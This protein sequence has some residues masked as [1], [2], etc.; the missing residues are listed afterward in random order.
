MEPVLPYVS[1]TWSAFAEGGFLKLLPLEEL[2]T[3]AAE[4]IILLVPIQRPGS[5]EGRCTSRPAKQT[6]V[7]ISPDGRI[8]RDDVAPRQPAVHCSSASS[9]LS[10]T[11]RDASSH[12][13]D[14]PG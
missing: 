14:T 4:L 8:F 3:A 2:P 1:A 12:R 11:S 9:P 13:R 10:G 7:I 5:P 6:T